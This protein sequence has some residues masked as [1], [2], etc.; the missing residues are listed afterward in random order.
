MSVRHTYHDKVQQHVDAEIEIAQTLL[1]AGRSVDNQE[2]RLRI[3][4][5][6]ERVIGSVHQREAVLAF[7][8]R[9]DVHERLEKLRSA[10][11]ELRGQR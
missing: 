7:R 2:H 4:K 9:A 10:L 6:V 3:V 11:R 5:E 1:N 8:K